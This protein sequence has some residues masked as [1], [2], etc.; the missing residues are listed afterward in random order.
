MS[1]YSYL[2]L[3]WCPDYRGCMFRTSMC[4]GIYICY[5]EWCPDY[6]G[7]TFRTSMCPGIHLCYYEAC[8]DFRVCKFRTNTCSGIHHATAQKPF[9]SEVLKNCQRSRILDRSHPWGAGGAG[10]RSRVKSTGVLAPRVAHGPGHL[11][12]L[13]PG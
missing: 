9:A 3:E 7:C 6:R 5:Y 13:E 2:L 12:H 1:W 10:R 11:A 8:P 4:P